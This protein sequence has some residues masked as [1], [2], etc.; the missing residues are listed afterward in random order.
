MVNTL[1]SLRS[2]PGLSHC[3]P[4]YCIVLWDKAS[5]SHIASRH[6][7]VET[8]TGKFNA[9]GEKLCVGLASYSSKYS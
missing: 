2:G 1:D 7:G 4:G 5:C 8:D 6:P 9:H 3:R